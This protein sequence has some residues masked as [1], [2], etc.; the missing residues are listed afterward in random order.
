MKL[1]DT[2]PTAVV[3]YAYV[4]VKTMIRRI[5]EEKKAAK[6]RT[7]TQRTSDEESRIAEDAD[8]AAVIRTKVTFNYFSVADESETVGAKLG[9]IVSSDPI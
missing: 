3:W 1:H 6:E 5:I 9:M 8:Q 7:V 4:Q 2:K